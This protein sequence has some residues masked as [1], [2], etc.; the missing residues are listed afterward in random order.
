MIDVVEEFGFNAG[1]IWKALNEKGPLN[2]EQLLEETCLRN[3]EFFAAVGWLARENKIRRDG[4]MYV[5]DETNLTFEIGEDAGKIWNFLH[6][7][8]ESDTEHLTRLI[9]KDESNIF[10][11]LGWLAREN[12]IHLRKKDIN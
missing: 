10:S 4:E 1:R 12:K 7:D 11:A 3:H 2:E 5:L 9:Q 6:P 8:M